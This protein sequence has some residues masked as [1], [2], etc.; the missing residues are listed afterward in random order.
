MTPERP[1]PARLVAYQA[2]RAVTRGQVTL[3]DALVPV[4]RHLEDE[5]D[6]ALA[7]EIA[8]GTLRW[9]AELDAVIAACADRPAPR[10]DPEV[11]DI[12]RLSAYQL[13]HLE[14]VPARAVVDDAVELARTAG[15]RS[16]AGLVNAVL[17][18]IDRERDRL[19]LPPR[20]SLADAAAAADYLS[21][22]LSH[23]R[24]L[25]ERWLARL[26]FEAAEAW[27]RFNNAP[28]PLTLRANTL[29]TDRDRLAAHL[30]ILGVETAPTLYAPQG[31]RV[32]RGNPL[33]T[34]AAAEGLFF[35]QDEASQ[36]V[37]LAVGARGGERV[38][39]ACAS[40]G[41][42]TISMAG[43]MAD[44][45]LVVASDLRPRRVALLR[46][47]VARSGARSVRVL[48]LDAS[49]PL[50]FGPVFDRVLVDA[51]CSGLGTIRRD[52]EI[53]WRRTE[54]DLA[55]LAAKQRA[56]LEEAS[57]VVRPG[58]RLVYSTCSSEP[59]EN[60]DVVAA[61]L[62]DHPD[63]ESRSVGDEP[64]SLLLPTLV[65]RAG[66]LRTSPHVHGLEAFFAAAFV[67]R[68]G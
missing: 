27:E 24:W 40:P 2:L 26:G 63:F 15:K 19:P 11:L 16:A 53:R 14:R 31:L 45:G 25:A 49:A 23:P 6:R 56:L 47:T 20:P 22:T 64:G 33:A 37:A 38:L 46:D 5:R 7:A 10:L 9:L 57:T 17:R 36:L 68:P 30:V 43:A 67:R 21:V 18:R 66:C 1:A 28:A 59:Q 8:A 39:D 12:L 50:P 4:R 55:D 48:R 29:T 13:L 3:P 54:A 42:K 61:W 65:D 34:P 32:V 52:P 44:R 62:A 41:G 35:V 58:G 51:P 60:E